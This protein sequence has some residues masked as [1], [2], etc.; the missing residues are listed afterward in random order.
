[1]HVTGDRRDDFWF[2]DTVLDAHFAAEPAGLDLL[3]AEVEPWTHKY[4]LVPVKRG[5]FAGRPAEGLLRAA[6]GAS[7]LVVGDRG[8]GWPV[9]TVLGS[10]ADRAIDRADGPVAVVKGERR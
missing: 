8:H 3:A 7:L 9:R 6:T 2:D 10:V 5:V 4:P 1:V